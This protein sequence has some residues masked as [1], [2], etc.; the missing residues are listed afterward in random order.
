MRQARA[1]KTTISLTFLSG[2]ITNHAAQRLVVRRGTRGRIASR[3]RWQRAVELG[4]VEVGIPPAVH[5]AFALSSS[6]P[7]LTEQALLH[8]E[9]ARLGA[10]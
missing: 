7:Q 2:P 5:E 9:Q 3:A 1:S 6:G 10:A 4:D 8:R